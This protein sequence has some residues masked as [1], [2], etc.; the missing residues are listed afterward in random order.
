MVHGHTWRLAPQAGIPTATT[1]NPDSMGTWAQGN[2]TAPGY[3]L[4]QTH[5]LGKCQTET[6]LCSYVITNT[7]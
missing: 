3:R 4:S 1:G 7:F 2:P 5:C 6:L